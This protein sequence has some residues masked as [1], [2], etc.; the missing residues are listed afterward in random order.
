MKTVIVGS[1]P[2]GL[3]AA[4]AASTANNEV[5][6]C[7]QLPRPGRKLLATGGGKC[8]LTNLLPQMEFIEKFGRQGR[9]MLPAL[10]SFS[11]EAL[12]SFFAER[13][14]ETVAD[15]GFHIFPTSNSANDILKVL[16]RECNKLEVKFKTSTRITGLA[17]K[18]NHITGIKTDNMVIPADHVII[19]TG[20]KGYPKLGGYGIGYQLAEQAGHRI[21]TPLP[22]MVGLKT[23]EQWPKACAGISFPKVTAIINLPKFRNKPVTGELIFTHNGISGLAIINLAGDISDLLQK[24]QTVPLKI[25]L[26]NKTPAEWNYEFEQWQHCKKNIKNLLAQ[27]MPTAIAEVICHISG[28]IGSQ[29]VHEFKTTEKTALLDNLNGVNLQINAT[30]GWNKAMVTKGGIALK[31]VNPDTLESRLVDGLY[32]AGEVV[33]LHG[34]CGGYNLQWAFSSGYLAGLSNHK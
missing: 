6:V 26:F 25:N 14:V 27:Q 9:F 1:G 10:N 33:D 2:A 31:K 29:T 11:R 22:A 19:A 3:M 23:I 28:D 12:C 24:K 34:P 18:E 8:N 20:G 15:D 30:E 21:I 5:I 17:V 7:E 13:G 4:I 16:L 32:F